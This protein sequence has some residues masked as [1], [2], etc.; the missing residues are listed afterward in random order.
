[1]F[2]ATRPGLGIIQSCNDLASHWVKDIELEGVIYVWA[3]VFAVQTTH[4]QLV[5]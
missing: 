4:V 1:M 2:N 5:V 3:S